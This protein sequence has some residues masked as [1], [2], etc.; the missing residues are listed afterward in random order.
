MT[1][2]FPCDVHVVIFSTFSAFREAECHLRLPG[3]EYSGQEYA[4]IGAGNPKMTLFFPKML[5]MTTFFED[6]EGDILIIFGIGGASN[7]SR[8]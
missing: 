2:L 8:R 4:D 5:K 6:A 3:I 7:L 1:T